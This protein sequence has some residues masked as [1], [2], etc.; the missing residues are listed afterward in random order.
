MRVF[1]NGREESGQRVNVKVMIGNG[2][3]VLTGSAE[4]GFGLD[5]DEFVDLPFDDSIVVYA[6]AESGET[7]E[8]RAI[9]LR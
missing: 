2:D 7:A 3:V 5:I 8:L 4:R 6:I 1:N 9:E